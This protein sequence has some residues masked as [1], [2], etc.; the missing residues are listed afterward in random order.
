M[1]KPIPS[2]EQGLFRQVV[3]LYEN[4][5]Y[6]KGECDCEYGEESSG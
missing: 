6:K 1:S 5:Q 4:K 3:Q 2:K